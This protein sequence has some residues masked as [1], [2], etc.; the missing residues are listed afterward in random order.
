MIKV[1]STQ[2]NYKYGDQIHFPYSVALLVSY[3]RTDDTLKNSFKFMKTAIFRDKVEEYLE[4]MA[5]ADILICSCYVWNWEITTMFAAA[6]KKRNPELLVVFGGPQVPDQHDEYFWKQHPYVDLLVHGE[7][8]HTFNDVLAAYL[9]PKVYDGIPGVET[10]QRRS[11]PRVRIKDLDTIPSPYLNNTVWELVDQEEPVKYIASWE[12]NRGCPYGCTFCDWGNSFKNKIMLR[13]MNTL[14]SEIN[15]F[16]INDIP[17]IDVC[18]ANFG[19]FPERDLRLA[20]EF[21]SIKEQFQAPERIRPAWAKVSSDK[22]I[23]IAKE[24]ESVDLLR[25]VT[26][27]VQSLDDTT[28]K[29]IDRRNIKFD[30]FSDLVAKFKSHGIPT[31]TELI[32]GLPGETL[33][34]FKQGLA[35]LMAIYPRPAVYIYNCSVLP[36]APMADP[37]YMDKYDIETVRCPIFLIHSSIH[38]RGMPEYEHIVVSSDSFTRDDLK[39]MYIYGWIMQTLHSF[40][41]LEY[42]AKFYHDFL[43][44]PYLTFYDGFREFASHVPFN[45]F[46]SEYRKLTS[47]I[48]RGYAGATWDHVDL[49]LG[50]IVWPFEEASWL[51]MVRSNDLYGSV[52]RFLLDFNRRNHIDL[53]DSVLTDLVH[54]QLFLL[55]MP[56][57]CGGTRSKLFAYN[58]QKFFADAPLEGGFYRYQAKNKMS[59]EDEHE[60]NYKTIWQGRASC[61]YKTLPSELE[62]ID[63]T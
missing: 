42:V 1:A 49:D 4:E 41:I 9:G 24:L 17:Y 5:D 26:L 28:L 2:F 33:D 6:M 25:A 50:E 34:S 27:A 29:I 44:V 15:W 63:V 51:R 45:I 16:G 56:G 58:W 52:M 23:P 46:N 47:Y 21:K 13:D 35:E 62:V 39:E 60:W 55:T 22:L 14:C 57:V 3:A 10:P 43:D 30:K 19:I 40:G 32:I 54:F 38:S 59:I 61:R 31:Y 12:S 18:D 48:T 8:E 36:N 37:Q 11:I 53:P 7:G 20:Q